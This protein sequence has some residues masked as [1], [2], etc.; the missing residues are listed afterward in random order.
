MTASDSFGTRSRLSIHDIIDKTS[1]DLAPAPK[2]LKRKA[3]ELSDI[4]E[5]EVRIWASSTP[6]PDVSPGLVE[7]STSETKTTTPSESV[8]DVLGVSSEE[9][10]MKRIRRFAEKAGY[11]A[12][13]GAT[14]FGALVL[15]APDFV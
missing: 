8:Q 1:N 3:D 9:R 7:L 5:S 12:L 6:V 14:I 13:G 15:S 2:C 4:I 10:P 11:V